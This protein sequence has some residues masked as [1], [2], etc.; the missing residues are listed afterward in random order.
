MLG[1]VGSFAVGRRVG[2]V[3]ALAGCAT[4]PSPPASCPCPPAETPPPPAQ[5]LVDW[6]A[7]AGTIRCG[8]TKIAVPDGLREQVRWTNLEELAVLP[9]GDPPGGALIIGAIEETAAEDDEGRSVLGDAVATL[10]DAASTFVRLHLLSG[11]GLA[12][13]AKFRLDA[14]SDLRDS[15]IAG[16]YTLDER[17]GKLVYVKI[18]SCRIAAVDFPVASGQ[19][20]LTRLLDGVEP[21]LTTDVSYVTLTPSNL[22]LRTKPA[23]S[24]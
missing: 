2:V 19:P 10:G 3:L 1:P 24:D 20:L 17:S 14:K 9:P 13:E 6:D 16:D 8:S 4:A 18:E 11:A 23:G 21:V 22:R 12:G 5:A 7:A 15:R